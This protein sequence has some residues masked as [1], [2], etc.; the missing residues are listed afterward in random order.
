MVIFV[1]TVLR[2]VIS[3]IMRHIVKDAQIILIK[4][5]NGSKMGNLV[6]YV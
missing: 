4:H 3:A 6:L 2:I 1:K 5:K